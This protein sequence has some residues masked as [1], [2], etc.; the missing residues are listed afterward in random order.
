MLKA[1]TTTPHK[2]KYLWV[3]RV[4]VTSPKGKRISTFAL[5]DNGSDTTV[6]REDLAK[7]LCLKGKPKPINLSTVKEST[8]EAFKEVALNVSSVDGRNQYDVSQALVFPK[9]KFRMPSQPRPPDDSDMYTRLDGIQLSEV[10]SD[11]I[12]ILI[13]CD[14]PE[15]AIARNVRRGS[16]GNLLAIETIFGWTLYGASNHS[17]SFNNQISL[18]NASENREIHASLEKYWAS[19]ENLR[20]VSVNKLH[21]SCNDVLHQQLEKF[22]V[23]EHE[24]IHPSKD[25]AMSREDV[26]ALQQLESGTKCVN[27][28]YVVP[29]LRKDSDVQLPDSSGLAMKR[30]RY[31]QKRLRDNPQLYEKYKSIIEDYLNKGYCRKMTR[32]EALVRGL[33]TWTLPH[34]PVFNPKK[35]AKV[36]IVKDAAAEV[37]GVSLNKD[38]ITGPDLNNQL[39]SVFMKFRV[40]RFALAADIEA[41]FHQVCV[42]D[43]DADSLRFY[44][45]D[46][47]FSNSLPYTMQMLRHIF[48]AKDSATCAI[49]ALRQTARD[50][51]SDFDGLTYETVLKCFYVDDLLKSL[52]DEKHMALLANELIEICRRGGFRLTKFLSNSKLVIDALPP[53]E[54]SPNV[55]FGI[56]TEHLERALGTLWDVTNDVIT[57]SSFLKEGPTTKRGIMGTSC[58][59]FD[60][61]WFLSTIYSNSKVIATRSLAIRI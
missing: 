46:D 41:F 37:H 11:Q 23:L 14:V 29:M 61:N 17:T 26:S 43:S 60:A 18:L 45:I 34:H 22:W 24:L 16:N 48:G 25:T 30:F 52:N 38:L 31:L 57:F 35:P 19:D 42:P 36:R 51:Y 49:H 28:R 8:K 2:S 10:R 54:V 32:E 27:G 7:K 56:D 47:I 9:D 44:W 53:S 40:G 20:K 12:G 6:I 4:N 13:G 33:K 15:A 59:L 5:L 50:N 55:T 39:T 3:V 58:S 21:A 1:T